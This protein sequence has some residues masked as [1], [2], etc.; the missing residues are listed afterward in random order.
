MGDLSDPFDDKDKGSSTSFY[1]G[2]TIGSGSA[3]GGKPGY[4]SAAS[5]A[6][7]FFSSLSN[8]QYQFGGYKK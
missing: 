6:D 5:G 3:F 1:M 2:G 8:Q 4:N 7:D